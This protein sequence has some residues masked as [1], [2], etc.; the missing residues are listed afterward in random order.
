[1]DGPDQENV[2][3]GEPPTAVKFIV[4]FDEFKH[5]SAV[6]TAVKVAAVQL[7]NTTLSV[8]VPGVL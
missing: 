2:G 3:D 6:T 1:M 7:L 8:Q 4:P 5:A